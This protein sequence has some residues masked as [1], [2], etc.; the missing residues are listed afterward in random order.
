MKYI[1]KAKYTKPYTVVDA[2]E[3]ALQKELNSY[4]FYDQLLKD[5][6]DLSL[7]SMLRKL[8]DSEEA[9]IRGIQKMLDN[10]EGNAGI[11]I[12]RGVKYETEEKY[13]KPKGAREALNL[14]LVR[15]KSAFDFYSYFCKQLIGHTESLPLLVILKK[16]SNVEESHIQIVEHMLE[17]I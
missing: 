4:K 10:E 9:H 15:E 12:R 6:K 7:L 2:L 5:I 16:L 11:Q 13:T 14:A 3:V 1:K 8:R 17:N